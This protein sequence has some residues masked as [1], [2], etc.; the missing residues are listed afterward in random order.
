M[1]DPTLPTYH[2]ITAITSDGHAEEWLLTDSDLARLRD[3]ATRLGEKHELRGRTELSSIARTA[4][5]LL[6]L[7]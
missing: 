3:R 4:L 5:S 2:R 7:K 1:S 6:G